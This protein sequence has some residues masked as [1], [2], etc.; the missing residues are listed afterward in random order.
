LKNPHTNRSAAK[1]VGGDQAAV[2]AFHTNSHTGS[3]AAQ[4][5]TQRRGE[6]ENHRSHEAALG[7]ETGRIGEG[8]EGLGKEGRHR[9]GHCKKS[10]GV[11]SN[12]SLQ[13]VE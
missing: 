6:K 4:T 12:K 8:A 10:S 3:R 9:K 13:W 11:D 5:E 2:S 7:I 1:A